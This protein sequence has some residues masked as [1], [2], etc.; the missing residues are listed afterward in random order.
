NY[1]D[2]TLYVDYIASQ[3]GTTAVTRLSE[4]MMS[5]GYFS[6]RFPRGDDDTG[7]AGGAVLGGT[8]DPSLMDFN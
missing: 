1:P 3:G 4:N 2:A 6:Q 7:G 5:V 8:L